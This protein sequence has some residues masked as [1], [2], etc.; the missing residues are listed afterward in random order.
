MNDPN[1][2]RNVRISI[3]DLRTKRLRPLRPGLGARWSPSGR[4]IVFSNG[5][6]VYVM[7]AD[8]SHIRQLTHAPPPLP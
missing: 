8:G 1:P 2:L 5:R 6:D 4:E 3:L 7:N